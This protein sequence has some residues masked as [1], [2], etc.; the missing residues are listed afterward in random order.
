MHR[1][2]VTSHLLAVVTAVLAGLF[3]VHP[4][5]DRWTPVYPIFERLITGLFAPPPGPDTLPNVR[6]VGITDRTDVEALAEALDVPGVTSKQKKSLRRL[7]GALMKRLARSGVQAVVWD[8]MFKTGTPFDADFVSGVQALGAVGVDV[9]VAVPS[10]WA[11]P[12]G[13]PRLSA[14]IAPHVRY[15]CLKAGLGAKTPWR[16]PLV[17]QRGRRDPLPS[18]ALEAVAAYRQP[19]TRVSITLD[20][21]S[22]AIELHYYRSDDPRSQAREYTGDDRWLLTTRVRELQPGDDDLETDPT[23]RVGDK[24]GIYY[25]SMPSDE[26][27]AASTIEYGHVVAA[28]DAELGARLGGKVVVLGDLREG[29]DRYPHPDGRSIAG[30]YAHAVGIEAL[31]VEVERPQP[32]L[33]TASR[34]ADLA[35]A[36]LCGL[37]TAWCVPSRRRRLV[38]HAAW[39]VVFVVVSLILAGTR[40]YLWNPV[41]PWCV[42]VIASELSV[43]IRGKAGAYQTPNRTPEQGA[44]Q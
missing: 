34:S 6:I 10:F 23:L 35:M 31:L 13:R 11:D 20:Q 3:V 26:V 5:L 30:V 14:E 25:L 27:L 15:G 24:P 33:R 1:H 29:V 28:S 39:V 41:L 7:H 21:E 12:S 43:A 40:Y 16:L 22:S 38:V 4:L 19:G 18:L 42:L 9:V 36:A 8:I 17:M 37:T 2:R 44:H 32:V